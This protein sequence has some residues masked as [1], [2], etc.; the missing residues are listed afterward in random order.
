[1][2]IKYNISVFK[3]KKKDKPSM[4]F[5]VYSWHIQ[6]MSNSESKFK[7]WKGFSC[8]QLRLPLQ[9][10]QCLLQGRQLS[11]SKSEIKATVAMLLQEQ[12]A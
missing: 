6:H 2:H 7:L 11:D 8:F 9:V 12:K 5:L 4:A 1:M 3:K 10:N